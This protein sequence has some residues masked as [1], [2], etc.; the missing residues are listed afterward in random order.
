MTYYLK[1]LF[2]VFLSFQWKAIAHDIVKVAVHI[3]PP[4]ADLVD[5]K[6]VGR[7]VDVARTLIGALGKEVQFVQCPFAPCFSMLQKGDVDMLIGLRKTKERQET[8][9]FLSSPMYYQHFPLRFY[10]NTKN[11]IKIDTYEDLEG[12]TVGVLRS[13][14]YFERFDKDKELI[15]IEKP[16]NSL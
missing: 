15:K 12:L 11:V 6:F 4:A 8:I 3:E 13:G 14:S 9:S 16:I 10:V 2:L 5:N 7:N 1:L